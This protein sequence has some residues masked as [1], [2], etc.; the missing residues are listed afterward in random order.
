MVSKYSQN[1]TNRNNHHLLLSETS[2]AMVVASNQGWILSRSFPISCDTKS[3][4]EMPGL[5]AMLVMH[6]TSH[7]PTTVFV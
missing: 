2:A 4:T 1:T 7:T 5:E 6:S 3:G